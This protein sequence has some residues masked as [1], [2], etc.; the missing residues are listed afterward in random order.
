MEVE[1]STAAN[2]AGF[3][4]CRSHRLLFVSVCGGAR[5]ALSELVTTGFLNI[6]GERR[7]RREEGRGKEE[8]EIP[9][10]SRVPIQFPINK[11]CTSYHCN[12]T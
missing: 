2:S 3:G 5:M 11:Y 9:R 1:A 8:S 6:L 7:R 10:L 12:I 4:N